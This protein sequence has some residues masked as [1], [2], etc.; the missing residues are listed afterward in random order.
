MQLSHC[1]GQQACGHETL[2][3]VREMHS[4]NLGIRSVHFCR[5]KDII[6]QCLYNELAKPLESVIDL[7]LAGFVLKLR[8]P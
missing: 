4:L 6:T 8:K 2:G 1:S 3:L 7:R 5:V